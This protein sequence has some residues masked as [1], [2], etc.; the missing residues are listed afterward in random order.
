MRELVESGVELVTL[1]QPTSRVGGSHDR[2][3]ARAEAVVVA[4]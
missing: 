4:W 3:E 1:G 2:Q